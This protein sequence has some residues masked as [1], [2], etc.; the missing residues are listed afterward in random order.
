MRIMIRTTILIGAALCCLALTATAEV[1]KVKG[2]GEIV[3]KGTFKPSAA[4]E[5]AAITEAKKN[6]LARYTADFD[7]ARIALYKRIEPEI[8]ANLNQYVPDYTQLDQEID[9]PSKRFS[10]IIEA[11]ID[12]TRI[13]N[14]IQK[15][16]GPTV[17]P[18]TSITP[19]ETNYMAFLFVARELA[20][21]KA[22][23]IK[24]NT[25]LQVESSDSGKEANK[26]SED[27]QSAEKSLDK[28]SIAA[29][30]TGG[31]TVT[32]ADEL[33]YRVT[34]VTEVD[35]AVNSVLTK[36]GYETVAAV[37]ADLAAMTSQNRRTLRL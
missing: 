29:T 22:F 35:N 26:V 24:R 16:S 20:S 21:S 34:T 36:A 33:A 23:D 30:T 11:S 10:V 32:K 1:V 28:S 15:S 2:N 25:V 12:T 8:L 27:G 18:V 4:E 19:A 37:D 5:Q 31:S 6:A 17:Q 7:P 14:A 3:Y 9:K 13:E